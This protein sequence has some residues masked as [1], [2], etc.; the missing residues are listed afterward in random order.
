MRMPILAYF[1]DVGTVLFGGL[2]LVSTKLESKPLAKNW[3]SVSRHAR[4]GRRAGPLFL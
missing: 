3:R 2:V 4:S 1:L